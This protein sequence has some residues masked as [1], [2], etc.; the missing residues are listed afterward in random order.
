MGVMGSA[1][2]RGAQTHVMASAKHLAVNSIEDSRFS[3]DVT[4][5]ERALREVYLPHFR[6]AVQDAGVASIMSAYNSMNGT[7]CAENRP[8]LT[9]ILKEE[10]GFQGFVESDWILGTYSTEPSLQ[11]GLDIEMPFPNWYGEKLLAAVNRGA[12]EALVDASVRRSLHT[13]SCFDLGPSDPANSESHGDLAREVAERAIVLLKNEGDLLPLAGAFAVIGPLADEVN[14]GDGGSSSVN[15]LGRGHRARGLRE[16]GCR[17]GHRVRHG[18]GRGGGGQ[19]RQ[20]RGRVPDR[21]R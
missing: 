4:I 12:D 14:I 20:R 15:P 21:R 8:L 11:A 1:F 17:P 6:R 18:H 16:R 9:E 2:I 7:Y 5:G 10:W 3:V 19:H 13:R